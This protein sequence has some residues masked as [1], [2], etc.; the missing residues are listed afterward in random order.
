MEN[1]ASTAADAPVS[2]RLAGFRSARNNTKAVNGNSRSVTD[3]KAICD[4]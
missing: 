4:V 1:L 3:E 2:L